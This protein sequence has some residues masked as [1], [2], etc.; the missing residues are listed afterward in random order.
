MKTKRGS[1]AVE[2][3]LILPVLLLLL[4]GIIDWAWFQKEFHWE[5][6]VPRTFTRFD[7]WTVAQSSTRASWACAALIWASFASFWAAESA[8]GFWPSR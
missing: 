1:T 2:F 4:A 5:I 7:P 3:S 8:D 6:W